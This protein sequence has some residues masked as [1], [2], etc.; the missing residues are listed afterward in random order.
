VVFAKSF[1]KSKAEE[2]ADSAAL[3]NA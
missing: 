1:L 2:S 3:A